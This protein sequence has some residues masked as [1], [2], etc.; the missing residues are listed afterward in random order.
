MLFLVA[1]P[2][3]EHYEQ[4]IAGLL[5]A[6]PSQEAA[7]GEAIA[8]AAWRPAFPLPHQCLAWPPIA[9][10]VVRGAAPSRGRISAAG[11]GR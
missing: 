7:L 2:G 10:P 11:Y 6:P 5:A 3:H 4:E 9:L 1:P 8:T